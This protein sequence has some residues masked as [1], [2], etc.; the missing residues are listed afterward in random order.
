MFLLV[1]NEQPTSREVLRTP[2]LQTLHEDEKIHL[3]KFCTYKKTYFNQ[4]IQ[5]LFDI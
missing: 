1:N 2:V 4:G 5:F 3:V